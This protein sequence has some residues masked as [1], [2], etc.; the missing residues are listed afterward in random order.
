MRDAAGD[1]AIV[2]AVEHVVGMAA[3]GQAVV[4]DGPLMAWVAA[5]CAKIP[6]TFTQTCHGAGYGE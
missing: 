5:L 2:P 3:A 1:R 4:G 6:L